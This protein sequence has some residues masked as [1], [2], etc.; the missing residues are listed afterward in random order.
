MSGQITFFEKNVIDL[1]NENVTITV[2]DSVADENGQDFV[3][4]VRNRNLTSAWLTTGSTDAAN[5]QLDFE[6]VDQNTISEIIL[7]RHNWKAFTIQYWNGS[8]FVDFSTPISETVNADSTSIFSFTAVQTD[9]IRIIITAAQVVDAD[10]QL[11]QIIVTN[12]ILTGA[13]NG[14]P[15]IRS[16]RHST[17]K[18]VTPMLSG[19]RNVIESLGFFSCQLSVESWRD[20]EDLTLIERIYFGRNPVLLWLSGGVEEQFSTNRIGYR[21]EDFYL[22]RPTDDY[23]PEYLKGL[24]KS[25]L[26][27]SMKLEEVI[28]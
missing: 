19:K 25:G 6:W 23:T 27:I 24:Y 17:N 28:R 15:V 20:D 1:D 12:K 16:P 22:V 7:V 14:W 8:S 3:N 11:F 9:Q 5:T 18:I 10:K 21:N 4:F 26:K 13:L 2:T